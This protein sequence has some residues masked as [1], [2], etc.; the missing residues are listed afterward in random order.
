MHCRLLGVAYLEGRLHALHRLALAPI[1]LGIA[2]VVGVLVGVIA[3]LYPAW[4]AAR[5][6]PIDALRYE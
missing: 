5:V 6:N 3:G 4:R 2:V 1:W